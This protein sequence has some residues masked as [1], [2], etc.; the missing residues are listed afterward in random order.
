MATAPRQAPVA[1][2][3]R[4][5]VMA[6]APRQ[7]PVATEA[8]AEVPV[9]AAQGLAPASG[10]RAVVVEV[11][12]DD[13]PPPGCDQ[14]ASFSTL[15]PE[16]QEGALVRRR[17]GHIVARGRGHGAEASSSHAGHSAQVEGV[18]DDPPAFAD[19]QAEQ[20][21]WG[22]APQPRHHAR[23]RAE[24]GAEGPRRPRVAHLLGR[25]PLLVSLFPSF[26]RAVFRIVMLTGFGL[27]VPG[28]RAPRP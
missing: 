8:R 21:L 17:E 24:R 4:A 9:E 7:A 26:P 22:G 11:P 19:A 3:A 6:T 28:A 1:T 23:P 20:E 15:S 5:E 2:K 12:D 27:W 16:S 10:S 18:A 13:S 25:A 14:W